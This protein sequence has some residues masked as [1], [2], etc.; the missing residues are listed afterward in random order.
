MNMR[1]IGDNYQQRQWLGVGYQR[2]SGLR[3]V[4]TIIYSQVRETDP[5]FRLVVLSLHSASRVFCCIGQTSTC[6]VMGAVQEPY[7]SSVV[8]H[9]VGSFR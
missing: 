7:S 4:L 6:C 2:G 3:D 5:P 8:V 9:K 1:A